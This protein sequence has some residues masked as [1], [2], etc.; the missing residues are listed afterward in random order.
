[1]PEARL[2]RQT[3][4]R[5]FPL[6]AR[7]RKWGLYVTTTGQSRIGRHERYPPSGHPKGYD[8]KWDSG[9]IL[10]DH[11]VVY[12]SRG[13]GWL[14]S[15]PCPRQRLEAGDVFLLFPEV[16]HRYAPDPETGW[17]EH[18]IGFNGDL[19][20]RW[21]KHGF[22]SPQLPILK[23]RQESVLLP[24][25]TQALEV[26]QTNQAAVQ[27][28]LAGLAT[29]IMGL[30][31]S[32]RQAGFT[33]EVHPASPVQITVERMQTSL[34]SDLDVPAIARQ[35]GVSYSW[36]RRTFAD[37]T[38]L[39]P[40][41]YLLELRLVRARNLLSESA[42]TVKE[43]GRRIGFEDEHYFSRLFHKK[44]GIAPGLWRARAQK[45]RE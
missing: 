31:Y 23:P 21:I 10:H 6:S 29:Q 25:F 34:D 14:E 43:V 11:A 3:L 19:P 33:R 17:D 4:Y 44:V 27:Q 36:L 1:M 7:D 18:W 40:H 26:S 22:F 41:Q 45:G 39:S 12:I 38:G 30:L 20:R 32:A 28:I 42:L 13:G 9:R 37:H 24:L 15:K 8:F 2:K 16:W 35:L 5:Y